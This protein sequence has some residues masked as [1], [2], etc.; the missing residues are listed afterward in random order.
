MNNRMNP[1][2]SVP[3]AIDAVHRYDV[4]GILEVLKSRHHH[5]LHPVENIPERETERLMLV[6]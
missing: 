4:E 3:D 1:S 5:Q 2:N 6:H